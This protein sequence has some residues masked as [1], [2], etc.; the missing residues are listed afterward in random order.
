[1]YGIFTTSYWDNFVGKLKVKICNN[2]LAENFWNYYSSKDIN[3]YMHVCVCN[4]Y[5]CFTIW[6]GGEMDDFRLH[7]TVELLSA[8]TSVWFMALNANRNKG[9]VVLRQSLEF[10]FRN[11]WNFWN[12]WTNNFKELYTVYKTSPESLNSLDLKSVNNLW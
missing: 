8:V 12:I 2:L 5:D 6:C 11:S 3:C 9:V 10:Y 1:M 4:W 7:A